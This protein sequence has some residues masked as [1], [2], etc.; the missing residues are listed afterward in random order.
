MS[1]FVV[2]LPCRSWQC[3]TW[4]PLAL[5]WPALVS[6]VMCRCHIILVVVIVHV[7]GQKQVEAIDDGVDKT[8]V[9]V[10]E[11]GGERG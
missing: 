4:K 3:G 8:M 2:W 5:M 1:L 9:V 6:L 10:T 11:G 7:G